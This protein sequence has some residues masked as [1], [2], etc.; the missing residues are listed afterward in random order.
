MNFDLSQEQARIYGEVLHASR[1]AVPDLTTPQMWRQR[2]SRIGELGLLG[3]C[4]P[5]ALDGRGYDALTTALAM[6]AFGRGA[7]D[8]GLVFAAAAHLFACLMPIVESAQESL[9]RRLV[10]R[11]CSGELIGANAITEP[12]AG[13]DIGALRCRVQAVDGGY[14]LDGTKSFVTNGPVADV[15]IVYATRDPAYGFLGISAFVVEKRDAGLVVG[16]TIVKTGLTTTPASAIELHRCRV[17]ADARLGADGGGSAIF[18][19]SMAWER[20]CLF[21]AYVGLLERQLERTIAFVNERK[22]FGRPIGRNQ[23]IAHRIVEMKLRLEQARLLL[24]RA[25]WRFDQGNVS[26]LDIALSKL[27]ISHA[28]I[29]SSIEAVHIHGGAGIDCDVGIER[30][31]RDALPSTIFSGTSE[32]QR[33]IAARELGL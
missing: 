17:D 19:R 32:I 9:K 14:T 20:T 29:Q 2:W 11:L 10:P 8:M 12:D 33:D 5:K 30:M 18:Q 6:E 25:C 16:R 21:A 4:V 23:A 31:L 7:A 3:L 22:Q 15:F 1:D 27:C 24:Y 13:S 26:P 28:A